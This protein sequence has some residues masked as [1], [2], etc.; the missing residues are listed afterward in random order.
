MGN[1]FS[2][3]GDQIIIDFIEESREMLDTV[4]PEML[5]ASIINADLANKIFRPLH[6]LK[7]I[8]GSFGFNKITNVA[9]AAETFLTIFRSGD[10]SS[11]NEE[12]LAAFLE[13]FDL[14]RNLLLMVETN[15][16]D[17]GFDDQVKQVTEQFERLTKEVLSS[18]AGQSKSEPKPEAEEPSAASTEENLDD[19]L[20]KIEI[21]EDMIEA[22]RVESLEAFAIIEQSL[23][24][25]SGN[26]DEMDPI[27]EAFRNIHSFKG[28]CGMFSLPDF[29][30]L[31]HKVESCFELIT[32]E[33]IDSSS[34]IYELMLKIFDSMKKS[35][36][37]LK[38]SEHLQI[39]HMDDYFQELESLCKKEDT[40]NGLTLFGDDDEEAAPIVEPVLEQPIQKIVPKPEPKP[41]I[42]VTTTP[43]QKT[44]EKAPQIDIAP[45]NY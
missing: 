38:G 25:L 36:L 17:S 4:E 35:L 26:P 11:D 12:H 39:E 40:S 3:M 14:I 31:S 29:E 34:A 2:D 7:G 1:D 37:T 44:I 5:S 41:Q 15:K 24:E 10:T 20:L 22:F 19:D 13:G 23:L 27:E 28:N 43:E 6:T 33:E 18:E 45:R 30:K 8:A 9:H 32:S 42:E 21:T 16:T